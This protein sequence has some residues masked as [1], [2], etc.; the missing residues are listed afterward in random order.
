MAALLPDPD[1]FARLVSFDTTSRLSNLPVVDFLCDYLDRPGVRITRNPSEDGSKTNL[2]VELG[3][4][5]TEERWGLVLSAHMDVVPAGEG[6]ESDPFTLTD[7]GDRWLGR[8]TADMKGFLALAVNAAARNVE[9]SEA[10]ALAAPLVLVLTYDEELG[11]LGARRL[12]DTWPAEHLLPRNAVIGEPTSL[13]A[14][15]LH[16]GHLKMRVTVHGKSAHSGYPHLGVNA[17]EPAAEVVAALS[18]LRRELESERPRHGEHFTE[19]PFVALN[20]ARIEGGTAINVV[21]DRCTVDLGLR[22]LPE[23][24][25]EALAARVRAAVAG[26]APAGRYE[27]ALFND[28]P[29]MLLA[30][31]APVYRA[32]CEL[33]GQHETVAASYGTDAGW[34]SRLGLD[35]VIFGPGTIEVAHKPD[36]WM[37]KTEFFAAREAVDSLVD[38]FCRAA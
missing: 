4:E 11:C 33:T 38:R 34:L 15:R 32:V 30:E 19:T 17:I 6:W 16:K 35:C 22:P 18:A 9:G 31:D 13:Q 28:T 23:M 1:L 27:V 37:P 20:V 5:T 3:P 10:T 25:S 26:V 8:G 7:G 36:E 2:V 24:D 29:P 12:V 21:P 14:V